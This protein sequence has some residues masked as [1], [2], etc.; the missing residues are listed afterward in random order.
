[1]LILLSSRMSD[2]GELI[3][4]DVFPRAPHI[5]ASVIMASNIKTLRS[6][7]YLNIFFYDVLMMR[8]Q[9]RII[10]FFSLSTRID[11]EFNRKE[12]ITPAY[13]SIYF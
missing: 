5:G 11:Y 2:F 7:S 1:M 10:I 8:V 13:N 3:F 9:M 12:R 4:A 6:P